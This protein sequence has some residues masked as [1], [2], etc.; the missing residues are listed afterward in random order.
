MNMNAGDV[1]FV[2]ALMIPLSSSAAGCRKPEQPAVT[3]PPIAAPAPTSPE[4][5]RIR[6]VSSPAAAPAAAPAS[7]TEED[8]S[9]ELE[10]AQASSPTAPE[11]S[12][13]P[14][15]AAAAPAA[16]S[17]ELTKD[18]ADF[19]ERGAA[20]VAAATPAKVYPAHSWTYNVDFKDPD[21]LAAFIG[22]EIVDGQWKGG[23]RYDPV[24]VYR[25]DDDKGT[26]ARWLRAGAM[27]VTN[28]ERLNATF[29]PHVGVDVLQWTS[30]PKLAGIAQSASSKWKPLEH[31]SFTATVDVW[32]GWTPIHTADVHHNYAGGY[33]FS[34]QGKWGGAG[35]AAAAAN[36]IIKAGL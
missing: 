34:L 25:I 22:R 6:P 29:G 32:G 20:E 11:I 30:Q 17:A 19:L 4:D 7:S 27:V 36:A 12:A 2:L 5:H 10:L 31:F 14:Q 16:P 23:V 9:Q 15:P 33:G 28:A 13:D 21:A 24:S 8:D 3:P 35:D 1:L 26:A 18:E